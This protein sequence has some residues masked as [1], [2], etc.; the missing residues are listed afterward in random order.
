M[1]GY[2]VPVLSD[3]RLMK[4]AVFMKSY[5][6]LEKMDPKTREAYSLVF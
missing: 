3:D 1:E 5:K 6:S 4:A 2:V